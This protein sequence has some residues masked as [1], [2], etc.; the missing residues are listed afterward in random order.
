MIEIIR[1]LPPK[2]EGAVFDMDDTLLDNHQGNDPTLNLHARARLQ[3]VHE[4]GDEQNIDVLRSL[5][6]EANLQAFLTAKQHTLE[7]GIWNILRNAGLV[8]TDDIDHQNN[9]LQ[10]IVAR[11][12]ELHKVLIE[13]DAKP[14]SGVPEFLGALS[15]AAP[16]LSIATGAT[17]WE[18]DTFLTK[19]DLA[20]YFDDRIVSKEDIQHPKPNPEPFDLGFRK[21]NLTEAERVN[22]LAF[23]DDPHGVASAHKAGLFVIALTTRHTPER[24]LSAD[25]KPDIVVSGYDE[26]QPILGNY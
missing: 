16:K 14:I 24:L 18:V 23:E 17:R 5:T 26:L 2:I 25:I 7:A 3:A 13:N 8:H 20:C 19:F 15:A 1:P 10:Q 11:K 21:L 6:P 12:V 22:V 9:H 4:L